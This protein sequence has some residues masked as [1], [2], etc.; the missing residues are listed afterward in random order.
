MKHLIIVLIVQIAFTATALAAGNALAGKEKSATCVACHG[1]NGM[2]ATPMFPNIAG[3]YEDYIYHALTSYKNGGRNNAIMT[4]ISAA[5][6]DEDMKDL[7]AYYS[8]LD[9]LHPFGLPE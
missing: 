7:A 2:S 1:E 8:S 9:G 3:Q 5:L 4:G 6:S